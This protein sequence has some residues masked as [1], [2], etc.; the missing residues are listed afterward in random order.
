MNSAIA[1]LREIVWE[2]MKL[3]ES[4][5]LSATEVVSMVLKIDDVINM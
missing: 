1:D 4:I 3:K 5:L 2:P